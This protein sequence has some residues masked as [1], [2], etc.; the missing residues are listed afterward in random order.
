M[1]YLQNIAFIFLL[2][3]PF[4]VLDLYYYFLIKRIQKSQILKI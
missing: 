2:R 1:S 4:N 3:N